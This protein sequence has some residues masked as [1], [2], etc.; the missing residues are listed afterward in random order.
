MCHMRW[1]FLGKVHFKCILDLCQG[2]AVDKGDSITML[3]ELKRVEQ[4]QIEIIVAV[5][6]INRKIFN[7]FTLK[8]WTVLKLSKIIFFNFYKLCFTITKNWTKFNSKTP[9]HKFKKLSTP[10]ILQSP[11]A[12]LDWKSTQARCPF[13]FPITFNHCKILQLFI[14]TFS[15]CASNATS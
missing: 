9:K 4:K 6:V 3:C 12:P 10:S 14:D 2:I 8:I 5:I 15:K 11:A 13:K 1:K 7:P